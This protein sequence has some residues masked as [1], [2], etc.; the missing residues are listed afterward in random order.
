MHYSDAT[1]RG[2]HF[3]CSTLSDTN[4]RNTSALQ[5]EREFSEAKGERE[6][7]FS[8]FLALLYC[9]NQWGV[10]DIYFYYSLKIFNDK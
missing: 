5:S 2:W 7:P 9:R 6:F 10:P 4:K 8:S 1:Y 3:T